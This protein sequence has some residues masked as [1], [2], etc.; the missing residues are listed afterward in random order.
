M[1]K[2]I[3]IKARISPEHRDAIRDQAIVRT[4][5]P[6]ETL[7]QEDIF[8]HAP[9]GRL[10][11]RRFA[12]GSAELIAYRRADQAGPKHSTYTRVPCEEPELLRRALA[13]TNGIRGVVSKRREVIL[14]GQTRIHLDSVEGLG[15]FLELEVVLKEGQPETEGEQVAS[16]LMSDFA[17]ASDSLLTSSYIDLLEQTRGR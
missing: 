11:L 16:Q 8:F 7:A 4:S 12:D 10:K 14:L 1:A 3:E 15:S 9:E 2:N 5:V 13:D 6:V 17:I